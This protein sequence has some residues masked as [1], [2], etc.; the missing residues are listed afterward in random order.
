MNINY[1]VTITEIERGEPGEPQAERVIYEQTLE[2]LYI[3]VV[4]DAVNNGYAD[5]AAAIRAKTKRATRSDKGKKRN[6]E[7]EAA[8]PALS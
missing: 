6:Q 8:M 4:I 3:P 7:S 5:P 2:V 1:K